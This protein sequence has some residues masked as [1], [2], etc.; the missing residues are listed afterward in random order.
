MSRHR[1]TR[2]FIRLL[3]SLLILVCASAAHAQSASGTIEGTIVDQSN[4]LMPGVTVTIVQPATGVS[5][6]VVTD[7][8]GVFRFPLLPVG[9]YN[10]TADLPGFVSRKL[11]EI[12]VTI[13]QTVSL[14]V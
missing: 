4:A 14:R 3:A 11:S 2:V 1:L 5:R 13:G 8:S 10:L 12:T 6:N 7:E 9:V